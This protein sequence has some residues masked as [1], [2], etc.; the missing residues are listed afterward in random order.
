M[1]V[2]LSEPGTIEFRCDPPVPE[3]PDE[4]KATKGDLCT[5]F[6]IPASVQGL[7]AVSS[8]APDLAIV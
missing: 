5:E 2:C 6:E 3:V 7:L 4:F 1:I 8:G